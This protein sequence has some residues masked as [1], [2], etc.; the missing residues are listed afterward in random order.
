M[1]TPTIEDQIGLE[2][3]FSKHQLMPVL[4]EQ[5]SELVGDKPEG[6]W[7]KFLVDTMVQIYL[8]RQADPATMIGVLSPKHG[9][10]QEVAS[11][12]ETAVEEDFL[13]YNLDTAKFLV[14]FDVTDDIVA[15]LDRYQYPLP[16]VTKPKEIT[17]N[18][19][20]GYETIK[21]PVVLNGSPYFRDVDMCLDHLNRANSVALKLDL[22]V[23]KSTEGRFI[24]PKRKIG[25]DFNDHRKRLRQAN[26]FYD[27]SVEVMDGL[28]EIADELFLVHRFD[29]R[30][31]CYASGY[32]VNTQGTDYN[33][34][35]LQLAH[36]ELV[37]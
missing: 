17:N 19:E 22:S 16:M 28:T 4:R 29:R 35:V 20:S 23:I 10:P 6:P 9:T 30:G 26:I 33:K 31:R 5:F 7:K 3:I 27:T 11:M 25:E 8:H 15:M 24:L 14:E 32:H 18:Q 36:E 21:T 13:S 12:L 2:T 37:V 1:K 34:A